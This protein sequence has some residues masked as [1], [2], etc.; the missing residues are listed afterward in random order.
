V[1]RRRIRKGGLGGRPQP[2]TH[3]HDERAPLDRRAVVAREH[4][5][6]GGTKPGAAFFGWLSALGLS[7]ILS[8]FLVA[9]GVS[10][11]LVPD[12]ADS[13]ALGWD[14]VL[15]VVAVVLVSFSAGGYVAGRMARFDGVRQGLAVFAW[16]VVMSVVLAILGAVAGARFNLLAQVDGFPSV[17]DDLGALTGVPKSTLANKAKL[18]RDVL[19]IGQME[20][21]FC[22]SELLASNPMAWMISVDGFIVDARA[23]APGVRAE[24]R[25]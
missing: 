8:T 23:A 7:V 21:E 2:H 11:D 17:P 13:S 15:L 14:G 9:V 25:Q 3:Q 5:R 22:R 1:Q 16:T 24:A 12:D 6:F 18:I 4:E 20:P 10:I 19:R